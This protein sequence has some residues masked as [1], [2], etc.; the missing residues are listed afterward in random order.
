MDRKGKIYVA[1]TALVILLLVV[2]E[3]SKPKEI[4]WFPTYTKHHKI[5]FGTYVFHDQLERIVSKKHFIDVETPPYEY[6][7]KEA[8]SGTYFFVNDVVNF[9]E[10]ELNSLLEWTAKGNTL[11]VG[12]SQF[13]TQLLDTLGLEQSIISNFNNI[14]N[15]F[16]LYLNHGDLNKSLDTFSFDKAGFVHYFD[17]LNNK[18]TQVISLIDNA[19][20]D[21]LS[22]DKTHYPN[23]IKHNFGK[24]TIILSLF[25]Q[26]F[27]NYFILNTPNQNFTAGILSY[28]DTSKPLYFDNHYKSGKK[29]SL[30]PMHVFLNNTNLKWAY[31]IMLIAVL[32]YVV[33]EGKRKQ[34]AVP[35]IEPLKNQTVDFTRTIANMYY[36]NGQNNA[37]AKHKI[38]H[39]LEYIRTHLHLNTNTINTVFI[40]NLAA[41]SNNTLADTQALFNLI[42]T[43]TNQDK[44][45]VELIQKLN[46][47]IE[48]FKSNNEWKIKT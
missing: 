31:Y 33:F 9:D 26:A 46:T 11:F 20:E 44:T 24:G 38:Q 43:I 18:T 48:L 28:L 21:T 5:P 8:I 1:L 7:K 2:A 27:T 6:L 45:S 19:T 3:Y 37:I 23:T 13:G 35:V 22:S 10:A 32:F 47:S 15:S 41:R 30:S 40:T 39:F 36:E 17:K 25:P 14:N 4:N 16:D 29:V 42:E 12:S 34:R